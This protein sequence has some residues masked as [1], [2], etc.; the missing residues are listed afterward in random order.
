MFFLESISPNFFRQAKRC[1][2]TSQGG[3]F[4]IQFHR[5]HFAKF[6]GWNSP[7]LCVVCKICAPFAKQHLQKK[8]LILFCANR[9]W[10]NRPQVNTLF[11]LILPLFYRPSLSLFPMTFQ[12]TTLPLFLLLSISLFFNRAIFL[13]TS[14]S[15]CL[16]VF[17]LDLFSDKI[18]SFFVY[19]FLF[20]FL[21]P[22]HR[23]PNPLLFNINY[24][25]G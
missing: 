13:C 4:A 18:P 1:Q 17:P 9:C 19:P 12:E 25:H 5:H 14:P 15:L 22:S 16:Y 8:L 23:P 21:I 7:N 11:F 20:V 6:V 3:K 2:L 24:V 10:W